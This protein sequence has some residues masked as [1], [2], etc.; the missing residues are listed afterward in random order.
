[1]VAVALDEASPRARITAPMSESARPKSVAR[2]GQRRSRAAVTSATHTGF[3]VTITVDAA[4]VVNDSDEIHE[5]KCRAS[6]APASKV[7]ARSGPWSP[8]R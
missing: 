4:M 2:E 8:R 7:A 1:L 5:A 3:V 6:E